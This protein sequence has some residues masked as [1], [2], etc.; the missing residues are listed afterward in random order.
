MAESAVIAQDAL[1]RLAFSDEMEAEA[2]CFLAK[3]P[4]SEAGKPG[5]HKQ[6]LCHA[7]GHS[8]PLHWFVCSDYNKQM[9]QFTFLSQS[10]LCENDLPGYYCYSEGQTENDWAEEVEKTKREKQS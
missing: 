3:G 7:V 6:G 5:W 1:K 10:F 2:I 8:V 9:P 4:G